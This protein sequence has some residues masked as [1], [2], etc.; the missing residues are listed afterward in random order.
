MKVNR[1]KTM[2]RRGYKINESK[3]HGC[4]TGLPSQGSLLHEAVDELPI[5]LD[6]IT[7]ISSLA[8]GETLK[9]MS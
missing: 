4:S 9:K 5:K 8:Y 3:W 6:L 1:R 2:E 7:I